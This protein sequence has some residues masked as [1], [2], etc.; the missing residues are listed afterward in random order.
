MRPKVA[1]REGKPAQT[2]EPLILKGCRAA[3]LRQ[4]CQQSVTVTSQN[5]PKS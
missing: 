3:D 2:T 1:E 4:V 5:G